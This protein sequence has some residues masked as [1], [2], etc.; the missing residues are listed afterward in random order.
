M[1]GVQL[2]CNNNN[3]NNKPV[4]II[5]NNKIGIC[6]LINVANLGDRNVIKTE[7]EKVL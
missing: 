5:L 4:I 2:Q 1:D 7:A 3:N 6:M